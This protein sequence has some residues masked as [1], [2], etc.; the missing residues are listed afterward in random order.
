MHATFSQSQSPD[1][2][3]PIRGT[4]YPSDG[5]GG[6]GSVG[7]ML[8]KLIGILVAM[9]VIRNVVGGVKRHQGGSGWSRRREAIAE[10][11]RELHAGDTAAQPAKEVKA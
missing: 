2:G 10:F 8:P 5:P 11:H 6:G 7:S 4:F 3:R 9:A 1:S